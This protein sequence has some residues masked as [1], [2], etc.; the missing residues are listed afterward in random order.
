M[1]KESQANMEKSIEKIIYR[2]A[3]ALDDHN[4][5]GWFDLC[6]NE[7]SYSITSFSPEITSWFVSTGAEVSVFKLTPAVLATC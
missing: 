3:L 1:T 5:D 2:A 4:W 7:F 6:D